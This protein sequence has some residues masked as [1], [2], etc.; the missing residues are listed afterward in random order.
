MGWHSDPEPFMQDEL[1]VLSG[2][3]TYKVQG[4]CIIKG[5][6]R[7]IIASKRPLYKGDEMVGLVGSFVDITEVIRR[8]DEIKGYLVCAVERSLRIWQENEYA[9]LYYLAELLSDETI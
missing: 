5:E 9:I 2:K 8:N 7:D 4:K 3:S 6:E 1:R